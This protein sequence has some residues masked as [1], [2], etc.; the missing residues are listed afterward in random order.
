MTFPM[1]QAC[2]LTKSTSVDKCGFTR[3]HRLQNFSCQVFRLV[4][5]HLIAPKLAMFV[6]SADPETTFRRH[7]VAD[8]AQFE[9]R[10][11]GKIS[12]KWMEVLR[13]L[14]RCD[15]SGDALA[16]NDVR[17]GLRSGLSRERL[18]LKVAC[19]E[20]PGSSMTQLGRKHA[21]L[22]SL[23]FRSKHV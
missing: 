21:L 17:S 14:L 11:I 20:P 3:W 16:D 15:V 5:P 22:L 6:T 4:W 2:E 23:N 18:S 8:I 7:T 13:C 1:T 12:W 10:L 19:P 9:T